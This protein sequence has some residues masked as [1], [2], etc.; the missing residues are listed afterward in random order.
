MV[1]QT[2]ASNASALAGIEPGHV[3]DTGGEPS[4]VARWRVAEG[5]LYS[6]ITVDAEM[7][8]AAVTVVTEA[9]AVLRS[10]ASCLAELLHADAPA[11]L[12]QC[13]SVQAML[14]LGLDPGVAFDAARAHCWRELALVQS[15]GRVG[16]RVGGRP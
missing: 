6:L 12:S 9:A 1:K 15:S 8:E 16:A 13:P 5:R 14:A 7:Y 3:P 2:W 10:Q 4:Q 11:V